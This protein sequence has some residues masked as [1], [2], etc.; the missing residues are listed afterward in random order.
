MLNGITVLF[1]TG[2][3]KHRRLINVTEYAACYSQEYISALLAL[4][5]FCG[6]DSTSAFKGKGHVGPIKLIKKSPR[7]LRPLSQLGN[8][9]DLDDRLIDELEEFTCA[10]YGQSKYISVDRLRHLKITKKM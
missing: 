10:M 9:W 3:G 2:A 1:D 5:A 4:H 7:F 6:C 8:S